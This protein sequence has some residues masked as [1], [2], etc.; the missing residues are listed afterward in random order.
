MH[1]L[2]TAKF[3]IFRHSLDLGDIEVD[4]IQKAV[5]EQ[6]VIAEL[7]ALDSFSNNNAL[8]ALRL[9]NADDD[10]TGDNNIEEPMEVSEEQDSDNICGAID[11]EDISVEEKRATICLESKGV[12]EDKETVIENG[13]CS[14]QTR[15]ESPS[16]H[17]S[18]PL[19]ESE[20]SDN[21]ESSTE[22]KDPDNLHIADLSNTDVSS[23]SDTKFL[24]NSNLND[25]ASSLQDQRNSVLKNE[26]ISNSEANEGNHIH[27]SNVVN[28]F[29]SF[30]YWRTPLPAVNV[31]LDVVQERLKNENLSATVT[32]EGKNYANVAASNNELS[33]SEK[34][35][36]ETL[37][38]MQIESSAD[39]LQ[40][41]L[42][43]EDDVL[44]HTASVNTVSDTHETV[45]NIGSTH[46]LGHQ[47]NESSMTMLDGIATQGNN[48]AINENAGFLQAWHRER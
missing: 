1:L 23:N 38:D 17:A 39:D 34:S 35:L 29:N 26:D 43:Q 12:A 4:D 2:L 33:D 31:D 40:I 32:N 41:L 44:I 18:I 22:V 6:K 7:S 42:E 24:L 48:P 45:D 11:E 37:S 21:S 5:I 30:V 47:L 27:S 15:Y 28:E 25:T 16:N 14:E 9:K 3:C 46:V 8:T 19:E 36:M 20:P 13:Q 10:N